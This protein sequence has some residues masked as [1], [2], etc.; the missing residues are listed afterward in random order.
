M[1]YLYFWQITMANQTV[2]LDEL[3]DRLD[4]DK[5]LF[6]EICDVFFVDFDGHIVAMNEAITS[7]N[8]L[9]LREH[10]HTVKGALA[11]LSVKGA[12]QIALELE[13]AGKDSKLE[14]TPQLLSDL[15]EEA[16]RFEQFIQEVKS[17]KHW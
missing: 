17:G 13:K 3:K 6:L 9:A 14:N 11:N 5:E 16:V 15:K 10:A 8:S 12:A 1:R 2:D 7:K 4:G